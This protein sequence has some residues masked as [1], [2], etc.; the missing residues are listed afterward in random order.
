MD[1][2]CGSARREQRVRNVSDGRNRIALNSRERFRLLRGIQRRRCA[3]VIAERRTEQRT[4]TDCTRQHI[5]SGFEPDSDSERHIERADRRSNIDVNGCT[6]SD[7]GRHRYTNR[8]A[9]A[10]SD[11]NTHSDTDPDSNDNV[12]AGADA[13][14]DCDADGNRDAVA[15]S[16]NCTD[17]R[18]DRDT[19][20]TDA[21]ANPVPIDKRDADTNARHRRQDRSVVL[22][23]NVA[24]RERRHGTLES[25]FELQSV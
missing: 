8:N 21:V 16:V 10:G 3:D 11:T 13:D 20:Y 25:D 7:T 1:D 17:N 12:D 14:T 5:D 18:A 4:D 15:D 22:V 19:G 6:D 9:D 23:R 24:E 2:G